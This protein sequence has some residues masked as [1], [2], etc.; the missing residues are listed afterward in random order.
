MRT[1][2]INIGSNLGD[3]KRNLQ[4]AV[5][6]IGKRA[7]C[8]LRVSEIYESESWGYRSD[9]PFYNMAAEFESGLSCRELLE[10]F[11]SV[12]KDAGSAPHRDESGGYA[13]RILD[14]D[15]ICSG[16]EIIDDGRLRV[17]HPRMALRRFVLK[18]LSELSPGWKH[19]ETGLTVSEMLAALPENPPGRTTE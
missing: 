15:I 11:Q 7:G 6:E 8:R 16:S 14:I 19:P 5:E 1:V 12:E 10:I 4:F 18:P 2:S 3:C 13:D 9:N 17:P